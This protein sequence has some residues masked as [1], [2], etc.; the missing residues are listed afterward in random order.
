MK[1]LVWIA[2]GLQV[3]ASHLYAADLGVPSLTPAL[4]GRHFFDPERFLTTGGLKYS[5]GTPLTLEPEL[6][7]GYTSLERDLPGG[8]EN[9]VHRVHAQAGWRLS[10]ADL[11]LS[12]A[13]KLPVFTYESASR[14]LGPG[15]DLLS[16][17]DYDFAHLSRLSLT[18]QGEM[19]IHLGV[20]TDL[21]LY[22]DQNSAGSLYGAPQQEER[23]GTRIIFRFK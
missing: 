14:G 10:L 23:L 2:L 8:I 4:S 15:P 3:A 18:W 6:G 1:K 5:G 7:V 19:G 22:Y 16:R 12:A 21:T 9:A 20:A 13:A 17:Q 11:Y